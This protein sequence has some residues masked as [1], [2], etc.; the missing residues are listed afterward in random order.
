MK[1]VPQCWHRP[2]A[3]IRVHPPS[4][5][6]LVAPPTLH[7]FPGGI[8][9]WEMVGC[10][11]WRRVQTPSCHQPNTR[12]ALDGG[13]SPG[14]WEGSLSAHALTSHQAACCR[15][16]LHQGL[17]SHNCPAVHVSHDERLRVTGLAPGHTASP[18]GA[19]TEAAATGE[20]ICHGPLPSK[21][22]CPRGLVAWGLRSSP[23]PRPSLTACS[24]TPACPAVTLRE[25]NPEI[26]RQGSA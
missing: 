1:Q 24:S 8:W 25:I 18:K 21:S 17:S 11:S 7:P 26:G 2:S 13:G 5:P 19:R 9:L 14:P 12:H 15:R 16:Y 23:S 3:G 10:F 6:S 22:P 4:T 20:F